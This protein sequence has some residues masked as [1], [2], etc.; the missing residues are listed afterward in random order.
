M[1]D[2]VPGGGEPEAAAMLTQPSRHV[3]ER[4]LVAGQAFTVEGLVGDNRPGAVPDQQVGRTAEFLEHTL[5]DAAWIR[6]P[7]EREHL[8]F[9]AR[10]ACV[11]YKQDR[12]HRLDLRKGPA[13][14]L[15]GGEQ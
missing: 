9:E 10:R 4:L 1:D 13:G 6:G 12:G 2:P 8:E 15:G 14:A 3:Q 7:A 5:E 11:Q